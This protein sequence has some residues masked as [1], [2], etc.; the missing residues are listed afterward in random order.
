MTRDSEWFMAVW[1]DD[2][3]GLETAPGYKDARGN[4]WRASVF[5][6]APC[7]VRADEPPT[8]I[9]PM[10][11]PH[12]AQQADPLRIEI[13]RLRGDMLTYLSAIDHRLSTVL[14]N[15]VLPPIPYNVGHGGGGG[16]PVYNPGFAYPDY[17]PSTAR[18][19]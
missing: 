15:G 9:I 4:F 14:S 13:E 19:K 5:D 2:D 17:P 3:G 6:R 1:S 12:Q 16:G 18:T 11:D 7:M 10:P 8:N